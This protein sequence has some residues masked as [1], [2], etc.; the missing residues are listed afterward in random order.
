MFDFDP[1][2][3]GPRQCHSKWVSADTEE[4]PPHH[5]ALQ[6]CQCRI[7][8]VMMVFHTDVAVGCWNLIAGSSSAICSFQ[9]ACSQPKSVRSNITVQLLTIRSRLLLPLSASLL[10]SPSLCG[11]DS[12]STAIMLESIVDIPS[13][14]ESPAPIEFCSTRESVYG[15]HLP[16]MWSGNLLS[17]SFR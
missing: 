11:P 2:L 7:V 15:C 4:K 14:V 13:T 9:G 17:G 1:L 5:L 16:M 6:L 3:P 8:H 10:K 12:T